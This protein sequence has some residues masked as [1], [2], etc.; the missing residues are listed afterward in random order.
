MTM[1]VRAPV[2][3]LAAENPTELGIW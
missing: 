1:A 2:W 3:S